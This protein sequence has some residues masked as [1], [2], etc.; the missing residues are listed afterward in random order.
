MRNFAR[1][2]RQ[3]LRAWTH[4]CV[5]RNLGEF[6]TL[7]RLAAE[8]TQAAPCINISETHTNRCSSGGIRNQQVVGSIPTAGSTD[9][10]AVPAV[11]C[12]VKDTVRNWTLSV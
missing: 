10:F 3:D 12:P 9:C 2:W 8:L 4:L 11:G 7:T 6:G 1:V 5:S